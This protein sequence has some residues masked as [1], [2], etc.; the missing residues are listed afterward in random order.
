MTGSKDTPSGSSRP[1]FFYG[2]IIVIA[3]FFI[4]LAYSALRSVFGIFFEPMI[5]E[6]DW[7]AAV[8]SGAFSLSIIMDGGL[9]IL[10]GRLTDKL[11]PRKVLLICGSLAG[12]GYILMSQVT[13]IWQMYLVYGIIIGVGM[14][15]IF[16]PV[17]TNLSRWFI[18][19]RN[20]TNGIVMAGMGVG[21]LIVSP[22][23][24]RL[25]LSYQWQKSYLIL[26][27]IFLVIVLV[28]TQFMRRDPAQVG[29]I[30]FNRLS[31]G[32][33]SLK[34]EVRNFSLH[35]AFHTR[36]LW[37]VFFMFFCFG[38]AAMSLSVHIVPHIIDL[39][40]SPATAANILAV[41]GAVTIIGRIVFGAIADKIG[42]KQA[43]RLGF[44]VMVVM[45][46]WLLIIR[47]AWMFYVF[48][49]IW[50]FASGGMGTIQ[51]PIVAE[52]FGLKSLGAIFGVCGLG[53]MLGGSVG[54]VITGY[55]FDLKGNY[56]I[57]FITLSVLA[58]AGIVINLIL[59]HSKIKTSEPSTTGR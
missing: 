42:G 24:Y 16:V 12:L 26:G 7:S 19:R 34:S 5:S 51:S 45:T 36:Q 10:M 43:Y 11:G 20:T 53:T 38:F 55:L 29:Q 22:V 18:V 50:G 56:Q 8:I 30:P 40:I 27:T 59:T 3:G 1:R 15:G 28:S 9:G 25:I 54:P 39:K 32:K 33:P 21:T 46:L 58:T 31:N 48:A 13:T 4:M 44:I 23:A 14:S 41:T 6:F 17:I 37:L 35:E 47:E 57:A 49:I 2:Y 52:F